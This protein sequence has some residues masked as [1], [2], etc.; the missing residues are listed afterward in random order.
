M[1]KTH[2][3]QLTP[4]AGDGRA[5]L[6]PEQKRFNTLVRQIEMSRQAAATWEAQVAECEKVHVERLA[7]M[8][9]ALMAA[10]RTWVLALDTLF[11]QPGWRPGEARTLSELISETG[12]C[13]L[14]ANDDDEA[15]KALFLKHAGVAFDAGRRD[16]P[17]EG[18]SDENEA[19]D[20]TLPPPAAGPRNAAEQ[21]RHAE[22][23]Q[24]QQSQRD[25]FRKLA[26]ALHPDRETDAQSRAV[27]TALMQKV[28]QAHAANDLL[29]LL[30]LQLQ[31]QQIDAAALAGAGALRL[32]S[33][34][35]VLAEQL[36]QARAE[37][38]DVEM[39]F[40]HLFG[41][42]SEVKL[43]PDQLGSV[44]EQRQRELKADLNLVTRETRLFDD[45]AAAKRWLKTQRLATQRAGFNFK[46]D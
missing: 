33:Y 41:V 24:A 26:S 10:Q 4:I 44:I 13:L 9:D 7:P 8:E 36:T 27:K 2:A 28:N 23:Q 15:L 31:I 20:D 37:V 11:D 30:D 43:K 14:E 35:K 38:T 1:S 29:G 21:R 39:N 19:L 16:E 17:P 46:F 40:R 6:T 3:L 12:S 45:P 42:P 34:N 22:A 18:G 32:K 25:I 5:P